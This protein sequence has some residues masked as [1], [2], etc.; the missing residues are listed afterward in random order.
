MGLIDAFK[1]LINKPDP[2]GVAYMKMLGGN[3]PIYSQYGQQI[4]AADVVQ[5][6][7]ACIATEMSKL[8]PRHIRIDKDG[9]R[10]TV[11][12]DLNNLFEWAPNNLMVIKDFIEKIMWLLLLNYNAFV[13]PT[14]EWVQQGDNLTKKYTGL[15]PLQPVEVTFL[16]DATGE[17]YLKMYFR[18]GDTLTVK[19]QDIIHIRHRFSVNDLMG[20]D[21]S[22]QPDNRNIDKMV[23]VYDNLIASISKAIGYSMQIN[24]LVKVN[25]ILDDGK[26]ETLIKDFEDKL[27]KGES[28]FMPVDLKSEFINLKPDPKLVD[29]DT[30]DFIDKLILRHFG[31]SLPI[32]NGDYSPQQYQAFYQK[33]LEP[34]VITLCQTFTKSL[35]SPLQ[36]SRG[37]RIIFYPEELVFLSM[38][39]RIEFVKITADRGGLTNNEILHAFGMPPYEGGNVR[40]ASL[41]YADVTILNQYQLTKAKKGDSEK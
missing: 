15:Y 29:K 5:Q 19:Y 22:G 25:T 12:G 21:E 16:Q 30:L 14:Y 34:P 18:S 28:G 39:Q 2:R 17:M 41:N 3:M 7:I 36:F 20:G 13:Y 33:T 1:A 37:N 35:I 6:C 8:Q 23:L 38:D 11:Q 26:S 40:M 4:F 27:K 10:N 9:M 32:L 31:V 24:G